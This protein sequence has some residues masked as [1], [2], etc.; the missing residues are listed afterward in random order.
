MNKLE[1][2]KERFAKSKNIKH[3][4]AYVDE[5]FHWGKKED[6]K[7]WYEEFA[8]Q[9]TLTLDSKIKDGK[10]VE[11]P[12]YKNYKVGKMTKEYKEDLIN[13]QNLPTLRDCLKERDELKE[14]IKTLKFY[15]DKCDSQHEQ[16]EQLKKERDE[17]KSRNENY[18]LIKTPF[19]LGEELRSVIME[20]LKSL[21][22]TD[23]NRSEIA[24]ILPIIL[25]KELRN[26]LR[27]FNENFN[28]Q[29]QAEKQKVKA[30]EDI[31]K[32][33]VNDDG[34]R[35]DEYMSKFHELLNQ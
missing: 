4:D 29:L 21:E 6:I 17:L 20:R 16:I 7:E 10:I 28:K 26:T 19:Q 18:I 8:Q 34:S 35:W 24:Y 12:Y 23:F 2:A 22:L 9:N 31:A 5:L 30:Y 14:N 11:E 32:I 25:R 3:F 33:A 27:N 15:A 13:W 1:E